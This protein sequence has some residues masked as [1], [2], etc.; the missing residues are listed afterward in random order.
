MVIT[1]SP[2]A[3]L[4]FFDSIT[5]ATAPPSSGLPIWNDGT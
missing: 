3:K 2:A 4:G 5:R 1:W